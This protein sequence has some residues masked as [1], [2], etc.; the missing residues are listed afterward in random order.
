MSILSGIHYVGKMM[1]GDMTR[2]LIDQ[3]T[4]GQVVW[5]PM[6]Q[7]FD[8]VRITINILWY[9]MMGTKNVII[10]SCSTDHR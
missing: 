2:V 8:K 3:V 7:I 5:E 6:D 4:E 9:Q 1:E 10:S